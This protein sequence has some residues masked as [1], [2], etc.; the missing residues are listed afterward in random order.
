MNGGTTNNK[1]NS[2]STKATATTIITTTTMEK[3]LTAMRERK[4]NVEHYEVSGT[5]KHGIVQGFGL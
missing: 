3:F 5:A 2:T 1:S 4:Q